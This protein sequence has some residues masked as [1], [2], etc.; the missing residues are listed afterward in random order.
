MAKEI[1]Y[2]FLELRKEISESVK[3]H[4]KYGGWDGLIY[5]S[6]TVLAIVMTSLAALL[7]NL[8]VFYLK[9]I[10]GIAAMLIAIDRALNWGARWIYHRQMR[11]E[12]LVILAK[13]SFY[14]NMPEN[15]TDEEKKAH[16]MEIY[17]ELYNTRRKEVSMPGVKAAL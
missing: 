7:P 10:S 9:I 6:T 8:G 5:N 11:H 12:Y 3:E 13:I 4:N 15:F 14:E 16:F 1:T 2:N 17:T